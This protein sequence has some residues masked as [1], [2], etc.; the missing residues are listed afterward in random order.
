MSFCKLH[1]SSAVS[2]ACQSAYDAII[3]EVVC[4]QVIATEVSKASVHVAEH[5][6]QKNN[7]PN[8]RVFRVSSEEFTAAWKGQTQLNRLASVQFEDLELETILVD[9]P[10]AGL[11]DETVQLLTEFKQIVYISCNPETLHENL[12]KVAETHAVKRFALFDQFPYTD[13][14]ECGVYLERKE[15]CGVPEPAEQQAAVQAGSSQLIERQPPA[16]A[17]TSEEQP[18][19]AA[20]TCNGNGQ[21]QLDN[22]VAPR[23]L[24]EAPAAGQA[25][26]KRKREGSEQS[27]ST[28]TDTVVDS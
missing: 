16:E 7:V 1:C 9:P 3:L 21:H 4:R 27:P 28:A 22:V 18:A 14:I 20:A 10:R 19:A 26:A 25:S 24:H 2:I 13:H 6:L 5:N 15:G 8:A 11:D 23:D 17:S 12:L